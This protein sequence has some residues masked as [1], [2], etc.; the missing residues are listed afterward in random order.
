MST[1]FMLDGYL[2]S[3]PLTKLVGSLSE[4]TLARVTI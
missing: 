4:D 3:Y 2:Y 1:C